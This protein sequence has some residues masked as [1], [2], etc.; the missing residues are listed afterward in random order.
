M[1]YVVDKRAHTLKILFYATFMVSHGV[2]SHCT[3]VRTP[4]FSLRLNSTETGEK[5]VINTSSNRASARSY[6]AMVQQRKR[7]P[8][9]AST[10]TIDARRM[11]SSWRSRYPK[12]RRTASENIDR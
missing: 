7:P 5:G 10:H 8:I 1:F 9:P 3:Q 12:S 2:F 11:A 4:R 6:V